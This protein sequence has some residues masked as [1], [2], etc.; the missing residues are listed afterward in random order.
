MI[1]WGCDYACVVTVVLA[2]I[3]GIELLLYSYAV[4]L[5]YYSV[6]IIEYWWMC[7]AVECYAALMLLLFLL[8]LLLQLALSGKSSN[9]SLIFPLVRFKQLGFARCLG[10]LLWELY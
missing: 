7:L 3:L 2:S 6:V 9:A 4:Q 8:S 5:T 10:C 1:T